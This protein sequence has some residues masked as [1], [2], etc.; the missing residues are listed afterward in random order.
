MGNFEK[1]PFIIK[2][3]QLLKEAPV[4]QNGGIHNEVYDAAVDLSKLHSHDFIEISYIADGKGIHRVWNEVIECRKGDLFIINTDV[5][6]SF[7]GK[8]EKN[9]PVVWNLVFEPA[10]LFEGEL[11]DSRDEQFCY[12]LFHGGITVVSVS[13]SSHQIDKIV[14][15]YQEIEKELVAKETYWMAALKSQ[16]SL[17]LIMVDRFLKENGPMTLSVK[18]REKALVS[19][20]VSHVI[21]RYSDNDLNLKEIAESLFVSQSYLSKMFRNVT[22]VYFAE[23]LR[24]VRLIQASRMLAETELTNEQIMYSCGLKDISTFYR[25]FKEKYGVTPNQYRQGFREKRR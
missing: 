2:K 21:E 6:H 14:R 8:D 20:T 1:D 5:P 25:Q 23:Y 19:S 24:N 22:G 18:S 9:A 13:L 4:Y 3:E 7:F 10:D 15:F 11:A 12:G 16:M 17:L